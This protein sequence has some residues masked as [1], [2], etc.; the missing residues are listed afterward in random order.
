MNHNLMS[1]VLGLYACQH[2]GCAQLWL[3][4]SVDQI[5]AAGISSLNSTPNSS[6]RSSW[7]AN[8][9]MK[10][11]F[12]SCVHY[13]AHHRIF[14]T[15]DICPAVWQQNLLY[16]NISL[17]KHTIHL[18]FLSNELVSAIQSLYLSLL[19]SCFSMIGKHYIDN[20]LSLCSFVKACNLKCFR[21]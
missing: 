6:V 18:L 21:Q 4:S 17:C 5:M 15:A 19:L 1:S 11:P 9:A 16:S 7:G 20:L 13:L 2:S 8:T 14:Y 3:E 12:R 10:M